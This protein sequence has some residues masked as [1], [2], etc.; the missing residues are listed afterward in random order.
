MIRG[1]ITFQRYLSKSEPNSAYYDSAAHCFNYYI[2]GTHPMNNWKTYI[3]DLFV[4]VKVCIEPATI[5]G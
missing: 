1:F 3:G 5:F 4:V 2:T